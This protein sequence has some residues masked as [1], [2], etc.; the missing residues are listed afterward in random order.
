MKNTPIKR[1]ESDLERGKNYYTATRY[2][3]KGEHYPLHWHDYF[4]FEMVVDGEGEHIYNNNRYALQRGCSYLMSYYDFHELYAKTDMTVIKVQFNELL[5]E[6]ELNDYIF[7]SQ[8]RFFCSFDE[9]S[10]EKII[11]DF[12]VLLNEQNERKP[13]SDLCIKNTVSSIVIELLRNAKTSDTALLPSLMQ[14]AVGYLHNHFR[15]NISLTKLA[16][17]MFV[18]PNYMGASFMRWLGVSFSDYL[19]TLRLRHA[20]NLLL[21]T[22]LSVKEIAFASGYNSIEHFD[23]IFKRKLSTTPLGYRKTAN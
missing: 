20:C 17:I 4:E 15:E 10:A 9:A 12:N 22:N 13:F 7:L 5:L 23:Y 6:K 16:E 21:T 11:S 14:K 3:T 2:I 19:N 8:N 1:I 18:T